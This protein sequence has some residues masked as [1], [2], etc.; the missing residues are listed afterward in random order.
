MDKTINN[1]SRDTNVRG[2]NAYGPSA[3]LNESRNGRS[4]HVK[5][6]FA[7]SGSG[8]ETRP[9]QT[10][11]QIRKESSACIRDIFL[12][13]ENRLKKI[14]GYIRGKKAL[15]TDFKE[16]LKI[17]PNMVEIRQT[18][19]PKQSGNKSGTKDIIKEFSKKSRIKFI[20]FFCTIEDELN[21]WQDLTFAD[22]V[23]QI[24]LERKDVSNKALNKFRRIII[25]K[26]PEIKIAYK[27]EWEPRKSKDLKGEYIPHFHMFMSVAYMDEKHDLFYL[28]KELARIWVKCTGTKEIEKALDV[29]LHHESYR[30][31]ESKKQAIRY[32]TKYVTK[33][34]ENWAT[35]SIG[36]SWGTIGNFN[37]AKPEEIEMTPDEMVQIRRR[38][39]R[40]APK[41][42][43]IQKSLKQKET[44]TF[45]IVNK[46]T[47]NRIIKHTQQILEDKCLESFQHEG[48]QN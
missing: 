7:R 28:A 42:H 45:L 1:L 2:H 24:K 19:P 36:R 48:E 44:P 47:V 32:A 21:L 40:I 26:Y 20:K 9:E 30:K 17:Y 13:R 39:R 29:A 15:K 25:E 14:S 3:E 46:K 34:G 37:I 16:K 41:K 5:D 33:H 38:L 6:S 8:R 23:M 22:D 18:N 10:Q 43:P 35:E 4:P 12:Q 27:R 31:I 11:E